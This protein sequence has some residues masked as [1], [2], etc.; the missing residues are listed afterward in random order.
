MAIWYVLWPFWFF[1]PFGQD[2]AVRN[3]LLKCQK[4]QKSQKSQKVKKSQKSQ[5]SQKGHKSQKSQKSQKRSK[6]SKKSPKSKESKKRQKVPFSV[7]PLEARYDDFRRRF[8]TSSPSP[9]LDVELVDA[10]VVLAVDAL[11]RRQ[12]HIGSRNSDKF[13]SIDVFLTGPH[14]GCQ[15]VYL[16]SYQKSLFGYILEGLEKENVGICILWQFGIF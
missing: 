1:W 15:V 2:K 7:D 11:R 5:K 8:E 13:V 14:N 16:F 4:S 12:F 3:F 6:K 10:A 9:E